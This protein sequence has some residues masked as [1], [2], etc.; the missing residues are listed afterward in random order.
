MAAKVSFAARIKCCACEVRV[1]KYFEKSKRKLIKT[2]KLNFCQTQT[3]ETWGQH[4]VLSFW[5]GVL[6][7]V[8]SGEYK[9]LFVVWLVE[10]LEL[11]TWMAKQGRFVLIMYW[12]DRHTDTTIYWMSPCLFIHYIVSYYAI[13]KFWYWDT[14]WHCGSLF[15]SHF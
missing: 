15:I 2:W 3:P 1:N 8:E 7:E 6:L 14:G 9:M 12:G 13:G 11:Q 4:F 5:I 10:R